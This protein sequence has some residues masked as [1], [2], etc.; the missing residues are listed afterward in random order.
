MNFTPVEDIYKKLPPEKI[1]WNLES[2]P[3]VLVDLVKSRKIKPCKAID[4]G[5][6]IGHYACYLS[7]QGFDMTAVD[8]SP[9]AVELATENGRKT[10]CQ[11][12]FIHADILNGIPGIGNQ[13]EFAYDWEVLH[14]IFPENRPTYAQTVYD[15]LKPGGR[16]L[17]VCF[18]EA[19]R[20]FEGVGKF[21]KSPIDTKLYF[22]SESEIQSL[23]EPFF[24]IETIKTIDAPGR[25]MSHKVVCAFMQK[26]IEAAE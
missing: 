2:P 21:R 4:L 23:F 17:S 26:G 19:D 22:S 7:R 1:P 15:L 12:R 11:C 9:K 20:G 5:C 18:S 14:H 24:K 8:L 3:E 10:G 16:Y 25:V 6:G 13:F